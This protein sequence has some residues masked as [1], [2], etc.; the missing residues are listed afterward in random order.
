MTLMAAATIFSAVGAV[1]QGSQQQAMANQNARMYE[2][3]A[4]YAID[5][6]AI[7]EANNRRRTNQLMGNQRVAYAKSGVTSSGTPLLVGEDT[8][9]QGELDALTVRY[10]GQIKSNQ[11][12]YQASMA[13]WQG[14]Q[15]FNQGLFS[16]AGTLLGGA[17]KGA[18]NAQDP[19]ASFGSAYITPA[20][21]YGYD[22]GTA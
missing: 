20:A 15:A 1:A 16:A 17:A 22:F 3:N 6:A 5:S 12:K 9:I 8:A 21:D 2:L 18:F 14:K 19:G 11:A 10:N 13:K 7:E 4:R